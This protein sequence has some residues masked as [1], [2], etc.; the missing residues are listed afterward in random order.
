MREVI[1]SVAR[2][3]GLEVPVEE[4][5]RRAG[6]ASRLIA[7]SDRAKTIL[8]WTPQHADLDEIVRDAYLWRKDHPNGYG[9]R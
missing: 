8:G 6:D 1:D 2:V 7:G 9:D 3:S 4:D 5:E